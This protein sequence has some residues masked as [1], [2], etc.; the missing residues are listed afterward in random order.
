M[1]ITYLQGWSFNSDIWPDYC[2]TPNA[3]FPLHH[4]W[5]DNYSLDKLLR[6]LAL[7]NKKTVLVGWSLGG[8]LALETAFR[9]PN[10]VAG[11]I[12]VGTTPRFLTAPDFPHGQSAGALRQLKRQVLRTPSTAI[13]SFR[14]QIDSDAFSMLADEPSPLELESHLLGLDYLAATDLRPLLGQITLPCHIIHGTQDQICPYRAAVYLA[15]Q[16]P[17]AR[18]HAFSESGHAPFLNEKN[19]FQILLESIFRQFEGSNSHVG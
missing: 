3:H 18:L 16:L 10:N 14:R 8:M 19:K 11:L 13:A 1:H 2:H 12:L 6:F 9:H 7:H 17:G 15:A 4:P 5:P